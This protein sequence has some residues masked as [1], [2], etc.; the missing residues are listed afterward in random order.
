MKEKLKASVKVMNSYNY[1][2]FEVCLS[3]DEL[4]DVG[5]VNEMRK[6]AQRLVDESVRQY[7][8]AKEKESGR[9]N[10]LCEKKRLQDEVEQILR[11]P[12]KEWSAKEKAKVKALED[13]EYWSSQ[14]YDYDEPWNN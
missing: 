6:T 4:L 5:A 2:H 8:V 3:S 9:A 1:C 13:H 7:K 10:L 14:D 12:K 11:K